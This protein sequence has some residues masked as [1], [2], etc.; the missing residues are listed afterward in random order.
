M[1]CFIGCRIL[2]AFPRGY[3]L[4]AEIYPSARFTSSFRHAIIISKKP[5]IKARRAAPRRKA[6]EY[7][8]KQLICR[9]LFG[10]RL[11]FS[12]RAAQKT[13]KGLIKMQTR[14][15]VMSI[16]IENPDS[17]ERL[18]AMLHEYG[19]Y[20][21]GRMGIP[22]RAKGINI[23]SIAMDAP[24]DKISALSGRIGRLEGVSVKTA[25]SPSKELNV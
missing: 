14:V 12:I 24:Q 11:S 1:H 2:K 8:V 13:P 9:A 17:V 18:N 7:R 4:P 5:D 16:I 20:I 15:A 22:Y 19:E 23:I 6:W 21:I 25:Y 3:F 10:A